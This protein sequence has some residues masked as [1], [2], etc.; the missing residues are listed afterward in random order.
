MA[1]SV[2][3]FISI[4]FEDTKN[5]VITKI[6]FDFGATGHSLCI[7]DTKGSH[8]DLTDEYAA[9]RG[10]MEAAAACFGKTVPRE[11]EEVVR[12]RRM[13]FFRLS[14]GAAFVFLGAVLRTLCGWGGRATTFA[15]AT[16]SVSKS[17]ILPFNTTKK[18]RPAA[19]L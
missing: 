14:Y 1:S 2:G 18:P 8:A 12:L 19:W 9:V 16:E 3:G 13:A 5:P 17:E 11:V 10:E 7:V 15:R 6:D 4:D